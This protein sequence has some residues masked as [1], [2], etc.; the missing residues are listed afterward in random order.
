MHIGIIP[1]DR[2]QRYRIVARDSMQCQFGISKT[3]FGCYYSPN[4]EINV[5]PLVHKP[6][7]S[8]VC[9]MAYLTNMMEQVFLDKLRLCSATPEIVR[10]V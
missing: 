5:K 1:L 7:A 3:G 2:E 4:F 10:V 8:S 9:A 6:L